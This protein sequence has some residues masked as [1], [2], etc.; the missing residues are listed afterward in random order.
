MEKIKT[1]S[2]LYF[3]QSV[4]L[5]S[6]TFNINDGKVFRLC[7]L[8]S[9]TNIMN[10]NQLLLDLKKK[11]IDS[12]TR[13]N[14]VNHLYLLNQEL[15]SFKEKTF[16]LILEFSKSHNRQM[17]ILEKYCS[18]AIELLSNLL[19]FLKFDNLDFTKSIKFRQILLFDNISPIIMNIIVHLNPAR[20]EVNEIKQII[21][22]YC[23]TSYDNAL[24]TIETLIKETK[25][26][27]F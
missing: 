15:P 26:F 20:T 25:N 2:N 13:K 7:Q 27:L 8:A 1:F 18:L 19:P 3:K 17:Y 14:V 11:Y 24:L 4:S 21:T 10:V 9:K 22:I 12:Y 16:K 5:N 23:Y 6:I